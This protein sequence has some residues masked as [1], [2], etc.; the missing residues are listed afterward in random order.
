M[1]ESHT[2]SRVN[3]L[4]IYNQIWLNAAVQA[5]LDYL[6]TADSQ[7]DI[8]RKGLARSLMPVLDALDADAP[9]GKQQTLEKFPALVVAE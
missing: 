3:A 2:E 6:N 8:Y 7:T 9:G 1:N 4:A 5:I